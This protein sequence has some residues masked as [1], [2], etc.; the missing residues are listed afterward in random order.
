MKTIGGLKI[1]LK[2]ER[3]QNHFDIYGEMPKYGPHMGQN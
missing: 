2:I 1:K 3:P